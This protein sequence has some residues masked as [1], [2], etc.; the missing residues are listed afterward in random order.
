M[1]SKIINIIIVTLLT[2]FA[3]YLRGE[4]GLYNTVLLMFPA[5]MLGVFLG[6]YF[7]VGGSIKDYGKDI[8]SN[9]SL[10][11]GEQ[12]RNYHDIP[13]YKKPKYWILAI[14]LALI[15]LNAYDVTAM[16]MFPLVIVPLIPF[17][18]RGYSFV[19]ILLALAVVSMI[20]IV[21]TRQHLP[22][23][24]II[25][26]CVWFISFS[27]LA[28][29][30]ARIETKRNVLT[31]PK[32]PVLRDMLLSVAAFFA[33]FCVFVVNE[34]RI[35]EIKHDIAYN[36]CLQYFVGDLEVSKHNIFCECMAGDVLGVY[37]IENRAK[38]CLESISA[39]ID[40]K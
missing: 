39:N 23:Y 8:K 28:L 2:I 15:V 11:I 10:F 32:R 24:A 6:G 30:C 1:K 34:F 20:G 4:Y 19:F 12:A 27:W 25:T 36:D 18:V 3:A 16:F 17:L 5:C 13:W 38:H 33:I 35:D 29:V 14:L 40:T 37:G 7:S 22:L 31:H 9:L 21:I 26:F